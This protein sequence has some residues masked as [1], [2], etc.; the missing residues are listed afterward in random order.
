MVVVNRHPFVTIVLFL[1]PL[2]L[3][4]GVRV[5]CVL[6]GQDRASSMM[7][8]RDRAQSMLMP[9][10]RVWS[11]LKGKE[12][13]RSMLE[14]GKRARSVLER[15]ERPRSI[16]L[17]GRGG[18]ACWGVGSGRGGGRER[19]RRVLQHEETSRTVLERGE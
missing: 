1:V 2:P 15:A 9:G 17:D 16:P 5:C 6:D 4:S 14:C 8:C 13:S 7:E 12:W 19:V 3:L 10:D 11:V 18:E